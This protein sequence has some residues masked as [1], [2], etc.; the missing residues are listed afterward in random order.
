MT[1]AARIRTDLADA[2]AVGAVA[3]RRTW[4]RLLTGD[5]LG[6]K[7]AAAVLVALVYVA[8]A[9][10]A[11]F[12]LGAVVRERGGPGTLAVVRFAALGLFLSA[13]LVAVQRTAKDVGWPD[14]PATTL[15]A[16]D[17]RAVVLGLLAAETARYLAVV[18]PVAL[19][20]AI[21]FGV[22][23]RAPLAA[24]AV[25]VV[26][27][28]AVVAAA[29][30]GYVLG[31]AA[32]LLA[33]RS[34]L[35][36]RHRT[37]AGFLAAVSVPAL[38][39][40]GL[41]VDLPVD[42]ARSV[43]AA[44][45]L[46]WAGD[47]VS[48][49]AGAD[50]D[51]TGAVT[52][53]AVLVA[54]PLVAGGLAT[55]LAG[56]LWFGQRVR[57]ERAGRSVGAS[58]LDGLLAGRVARPTRRVALKSVRRAVRSPISVQ[59]A[60]VPA[61]ALFYEVQ[62]S[63]VTGVVPARLPVV[64]GLVG[65]LCTGSLFTLN[66]LGN[67]GPVLPVTLTTGVRPRALLAGSVLAELALGLVP[68]LLAVAVAAAAASL[69]PLVVVANVLAVGAFAVA[70]TGV[71]AALGTRFPKV[72]AVQVTGEREVVVPSPWAFAG[73]VGAVLALGLPAL[74]SHLDPVAAWVQ[75][76]TGVDTTV[77][78]LAG[79]ALSAGLAA[80]AGWVGF[81]RAAARVENYRR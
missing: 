9:G 81:D 12:A 3:L 70:C 15:L 10:L 36:A 19:A 24:L 20:A 8:G 69:P 76:R 44:V 11:G 54:L 67:E 64:V 27:L 28:L 51:A 52:G 4:R 73:Y 23:A 21:G 49:A 35:V 7:L 26:V 77:L 22:G 63:L 61:F 55:V 40:L 16:A 34:P 75:A 59:Y 68:T 56:R 1:R 65:A 57:V 78:R 50:A 32:K 41:A 25:L 14:E 71:A 38:Y 6:L 29:S 53:V 2:A 80:L 66:P 45:P 79:L 46:A 74:L 33:A 13:G 48:L 18:A 60:V 39:T 30:V 37:A 5:R 42:A 62:L 43:V 72:D 47:V 31:L 58:R 17:H